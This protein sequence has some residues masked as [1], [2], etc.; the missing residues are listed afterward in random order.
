MSSEGVIKIKGDNTQLDAATAKSVEGMKRLG[1]HAG[2]A[3]RHVKTFGDAWEH[4]NGNMTRTLAHSLALTHVLGKIAGTMKEIQDESAKTSAAIGGT[5]VNRSLAAQR[6]GLSNEQG[7]AAVGG[8]GAATS[9]ERNKFFASL[10][11]MTTGRGHQKLTTQQGFRLQSA[12]NSKMYSADEL[13]D[14][15]ARGAFD[16]IDVAGRYGR[17]DETGRAEIDTQ[18]ATYAS[19]TKKEQAEEERAAAGR[20]VRRGDAEIDAW[21]AAHPGLNKA[22]T[23]LGGLPFGLG[24]M[25][26]GI[27]TTM[28]R[29][30]NSNEEMAK[31]TKREANKPTLAPG[32]E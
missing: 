14:I 16:E 20:R 4:A 1:E 30:A 22:R 2:R 9:E 18:A 28:S 25:F 31:D 15:A 7:A 26:T 24:E 17:L 12:F 23:A 5:A 32:A 3:Q 29:V 19:S 11:E 21:A 10:P 6:L 8:A 27:N 13:R